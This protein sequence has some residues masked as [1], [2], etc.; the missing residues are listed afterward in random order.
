MRLAAERAADLERAARDRERAGRGRE[1]G[2][3]RRLRERYA[4]RAASG[5]ASGEGVRSGT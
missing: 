4:R 1:P 2:S 3:L 5:A